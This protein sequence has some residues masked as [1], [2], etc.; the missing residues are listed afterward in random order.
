MPHSLIAT[1]NRWL[2]N[3][4][5][6]RT[7]L[8]LRG[9]SLPFSSGS[10]ASRMSRYWATTS[11]LR[12]AR[13]YL[14]RCRSSGCAFLCSEIRVDSRLVGVTSRR[15][16]VSAASTVMRSAGARWMYTPRTISSSV[17]R[18]Q[19]SASRLVRNV[20]AVAGQPVLLMRAFQVPEEVLTIVAMSTPYEAS[21]AS[22]YRNCRLFII[23]GGRSTFARLVFAKNT[24]N[25]SNADVPNRF[26]PRD[27]WAGGPGSEASPR[28]SCVGRAA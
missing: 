22:L 9:T 21:A 13:E 23:K 2:S 10:P 15:Y 16:R 20:L 8:L 25:G 14:P 7:V 5:S 24:S 4:S 12:A 17:R 6:R 1:V 18:A 19:S 27:P 11:A 28:Y 26:Y 3:A